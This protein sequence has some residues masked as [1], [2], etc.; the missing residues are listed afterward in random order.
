MM[1]HMHLVCLN[2]P[3]PFCLVPQLRALK[4]AIARSQVSPDHVFRI[5]VQPQRSTRMPCTVVKYGVPGAMEKLALLCRVTSCRLPRARVKLKPALKTHLVP[6]RTT[7]FRKGNL[8]CYSCGPRAPLH[9]SLDVHHASRI[10][11][12]VTAHH[13]GRPPVRDPA[14]SCPG[15]PGGGAGGH[16]QGPAGGSQVRAAWSA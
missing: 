7:G 6:A 12:S 10:T 1:L 16:H 8:D 4:D 5:S 15:G 11:Y 3:R 14:G 13:T 9:A 2:A